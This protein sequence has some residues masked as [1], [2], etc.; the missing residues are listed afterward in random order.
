MKIVLAIILLLTMFTVSSSV[1]AKSSFG[2]FKVTRSYKAP[3]IKSYSPKSY[4][5]PSAPRNYKNG[6][7]L[8][9]QKGYLKRNGT[10]VQPYLKTKPDSSRFNNRKQILDY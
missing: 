7:Q 4:K 9:M 5:T 8:Y 10:Y 6:G 3:S 1:E 2:S